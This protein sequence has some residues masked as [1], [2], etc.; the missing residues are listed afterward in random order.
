VIA[1]RHE[2]SS[3]ITLIALVA[4]LLLSAM[5]TACESVEDEVRQ[6]VDQVEQQVV[7]ETRKLAWSQVSNGLN[8]LKE[9]LS[10]DKDKGV[11]WARSEVDRI[12]EGLRVI[13]GEGADGSLENLDWI[14]EE[15][16]KLDDK[17]AQYENSDQVVEAIDEFMQE[18]E[19]RLGVSQ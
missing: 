10:N 15:L 18:L 2:R 16:Q 1:N 12:R 3:I 5:L 7:T 19:D 8:G 4:L 6:G 14:D 17:L 11:D 13:V 9:T